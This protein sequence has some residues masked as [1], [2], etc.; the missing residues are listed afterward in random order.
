MALLVIAE[1]T[2]VADTGNRW[3]LGREYVQLKGSCCNGSGCSHIEVAGV[4]GL[5]GFSCK[6]ITCNVS[7]WRVEEA[8]DACGL[9]EAVR[10]TGGR[11]IEMGQC[12]VASFDA[13]QE[14]DADGVGVKGLFH[15]L[16]APV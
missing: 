9:A 3:P 11:L 8:W 15:G 10:P 16:Q 4:N 5:D 6:G 12:P 14:G 13:V 7:M 1:I 2:P